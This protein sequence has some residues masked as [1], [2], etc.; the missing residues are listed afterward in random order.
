MFLT[1]R[2]KK[3][4]FGTKEIILYREREYIKILYCILTLYYYHM[5]MYEYIK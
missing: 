5:W 1:K 4:I 3:R 2:K